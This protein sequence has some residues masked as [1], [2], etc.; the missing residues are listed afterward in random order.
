MPL[1]FGQRRLWLAEQVAPGSL[2]YTTPV[3]LRWRG[4]LRAEVMRA[5]LDAVVERHEVLRTTFVT[6]RGVPTQVV[7]EFRGADVEVVDCRGGAG[8]GVDQAVREELERPFDLVR[9]PL[10]R[11]RIILAADDAGVLVVNMHHIVTDGWSAG[12]LQDEL[13][14]L[15]PAL[16]AGGVSPLAELPWQYAD[17]AVW[18]RELLTPERRA[19]LEGY[20]RERLA[21]APA[22]MSLPYD[23]DP[24]GVESRAGT[25][26][27]FSLDPAVVTGVR[28]LARAEN[29]TLFMVLLAAYQ[30]LLSRVTGETDVVVTTSVAGR[31]HARLDELIGFFVNNLVLR[32]DLS[33][34][35]SFPEVVRRVRR[36][37]LDAQDHQDLPFDMLVAAI[38]PPRRAH[39]TP[40]LQTSMVQQP[41]SIA[42]YHIGELAVRP[43]EP[44]LAAAPLD[45]AFSFFED[46]GVEI[47]INYRVDLFTSE[48]IRHLSE[49]FSATLSAAVEQDEGVER[50]PVG[51][52]AVLA[53]EV[54]ER[55]SGAG[56]QDRG[57]GGENDERGR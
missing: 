17:F 54:R 30:V 23:R 3:L 38:R 52:G 8:A 7:G 22:Y 6:R 1:S 49:Q 33:G 12:V 41:E 26:F 45:L 46:V 11:A 35:P 28:A 2:A 14:A 43:I 16:A 31:S 32:T 51:H 20:W 10:F 39:Q 47:Q 27:S 50:I 9:G 44:P 57:Y 29:S 18:Q 21:G 24:S 25:T 37:V 19:V 5:C 40:F 48:T 53:G 56:A 42:Q 36:T 34:E 55:P 15:Y 4:A 13:V